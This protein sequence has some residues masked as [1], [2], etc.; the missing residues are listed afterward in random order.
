M[1]VDRFKRWSLVLALSVV[2]LAW[3]VDI[4][5]VN[6]LLEQYRQGFN[7]GNFENVAPLL[8]KNFSYAGFEPS[9]SRSILESFI[10]LAP[11][12][13]VKFE[14]VALSPAGKDSVIVSFNAIVSYEGIADTVQQAMIMVEEDHT[15]KIGAIIDP[16]IAGQS[17]LPEPNNKRRANENRKM[18]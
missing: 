18:D 9:L 3:A 13:I 12:S 15:L 11:Y 8:S 17:S 5:Q 2:A 4:E 1:K 16:D 7:S 6:T 10:Y 14:D